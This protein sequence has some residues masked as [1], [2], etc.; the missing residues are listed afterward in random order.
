MILRLLIS[1][2]AEKE[3]YRIAEE[4]NAKAR[5]EVASLYVHLRHLEKYIV[6]KADFWNVPGSAS[7]LLELHITRANGTAIWRLCPTHISCIALLTVQ[8]DNLL[9]LAISSR[10]EVTVTERSLIDC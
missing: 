3:L 2:D 8:D 9:V 7:G 1:T 10:A 5:K 4:G 6:T